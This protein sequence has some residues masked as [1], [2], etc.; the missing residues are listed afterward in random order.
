M[1]APSKT[2]CLRAFHEDLDKTNPWDRQ[3]STPPPLPKRI[4]WPGGKIVSNKDEALASFLRRKLDQGQTLTPEQMAMLERMVEPNAQVPA[5][6]AATTT[7]GGKR[8]E[9]G[10]G[11]GGGGGGG[12]ADTDARNLLHKLER[13]VAR[14]PGAFESANAGGRGRGEFHKLSKSERGRRK[15]D[16]SSLKSGDNEAGVDIG[17]G[18]GRR[19][20]PNGHGGF[21]IATSAGGA[22]L[23]A[24]QQQQKQ[25]GASS[26]RSRG[27]GA[28]GGQFE[29][30]EA[31]AAA[32]AAIP[33]VYREAESS[34]N[35][36][37]SGGKVGGAAGV[38]GKKK[39][40][41]QQPQQQKGRVS[42]GAKAKGLSNAGAG[43]GRTLEELMSG[44]LAAVRR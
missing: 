4:A 9:R 2:V 8:K 15:V 1:A 38:K 22:G 19:V 35:G 32:V 40:T 16:L 30:A 34:M 43:G 21:T 37:K 27:V 6:T 41:Q 3:G 28:G 23:R 42:G 31:A 17:G 25:R 5:A 24:P 13:K 36:N 7:V 14:A 11:N 39:F 29:T 12:V 44:G 33:S 20:I 26:K 10:A 18:G